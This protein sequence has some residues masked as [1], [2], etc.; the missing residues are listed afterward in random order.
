MTRHGPASKKKCDREELQNRLFSHTSQWA[1]SASGQQS[2]SATPVAADGKADR[3]V[4]CMDLVT[5]EGV[6]NG[7]HT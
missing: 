6:Y 5:A 2:L 1:A 3:C 4:A 7:T